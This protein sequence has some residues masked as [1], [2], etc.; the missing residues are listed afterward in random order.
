MST[1]IQIASKINFRGME[2]S[3]AVE[4]IIR[5]RIE[6]LSTFHERIIACNV[7]VEAPHKHGRKGKLY[8]V[9]VDLTVPGREISVGNEPE[10]NH[11]HEDVKV[12][13]RDS[14]DAAQRQLEDAVRQMAP[15]RVGTPPLKL[16]G[17]VARLIPED[18]FG[19]IATPDGREFFFRKESLTSKDQWAKLEVG[20]EVRFTEHE[21]DKGPYASAVTLT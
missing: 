5:E 9:R 21:G 12:A 2:P 18:T 17:T 10:Q 1:Q 7:V 3:P 20:T 4:H 8:H 6:R 14:F 11:A 15:H 13:I 16:T 19:F